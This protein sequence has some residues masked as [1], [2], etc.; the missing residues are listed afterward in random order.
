MKIKLY[1][2]LILLCTII[3]GF[4]Y[5][6]N[7]KQEKH[8]QKNNYEFELKPLSEVF[9]KKGSYAF[10]VKLNNND[11][12]LDDHIYLE[13]KI[14]SEKKLIVLEEKNT[15]F[16]GI[17]MESILSGD[18]QYVYKGELELENDEKFLLETK[19]T[20]PEIKA[21]SFINKEKLFN[22]DDMKDISL[23]SSIL[24]LLFYYSEWILYPIILFSLIRILIIIRK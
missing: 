17:T 16:G 6:E 12:F 10:Y 9:L 4:Y 23:P 1:L 11:S 8:F 15:G 7:Y 14:A 2:G 19:I 5:Y 18:F 22:P 13:N 20:N 24:E 21:V 3:L